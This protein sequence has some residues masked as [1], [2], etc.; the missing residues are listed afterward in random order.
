MSTFTGQW[1]STF[2]PMKLTQRGKKVKGHYLYLGT[3][4]T[5]EGALDG[6]RLVFTYKEPKVRGE[7][8]F[9]LTRRGKAF[10]GQW[11]AQGDPVWRSWVGTRLGF[12]GLWESDFGRMRLIAEDGEV[13]GFYELGGGSAVD[14]ELHGGELVFTY[15]EPGTQGEGRFVLA[16][17]G[18]SFQ[19]QWRP[20]GR[21]SWAP[22]QG[23]RVVPRQE[24]RW[25]VVLEAPWH[26]IRA[27]RDYAFG[28]MLREFF[29]RVP[30][31]RV[32]QRYFQNEV[33]LNRQLRD[34]LLIAEPVVLLV[35]THGLP[36]GIPVDGGLIDVRK[37]VERLHGAS[38]LRLLHFSACLLMQ[39]PTVVES[40]RGLAEDAGF[41]I[42]GYSTSVDWAA[43]A[44]I[45]F[46]YL[47]LVLARGMTPAQ[48]AEQ[49]GRLLPFAGDAEVEG[50]VFPAAGFRIVTPRGEVTAAP[51]AEGETV[52]V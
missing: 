19:G 34:V 10:A 25:L 35:A 24:L 2:G 15:K 23:V 17:D 13:R 28:S 4:C 38:D 31:V 16:E 1:L 49:V 9:E 30:E 14:G 18:M 12:D 22:W 43:S 7:G 20:Q 47:E 37:I 8:W 21:T 51:A 5:I 44:I 39:D 36:Q 46:A 42:S 48:A 29:T 11:R 33:S 45:E 3:R 6:E 50:G 26:N 32:R 40:L 27:D 52:I 41:P